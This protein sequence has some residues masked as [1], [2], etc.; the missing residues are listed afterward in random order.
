MV[1]LFAVGV[2]PPEVPRSAAVLREGT[3]T[4]TSL[5][6]VAGTPQGAPATLDQNS[7][8][9]GRAVRCYLPYNNYTAYKRY[10]AT[11]KDQHRTRRFAIDVGGEL[12]PT[13]EKDGVLVRAGGGGEGERGVI[14]NKD[15]LYKQRLAAPRQR[16][17]LLGR[18]YL[19]SERYR[20][21]N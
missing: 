10:I 15:S 13:Y 11:R 4:R 8:N 20:Y 18:D 1:P 7:I 21:I 5:V 14:D 3:E 19:Y 9:I 6:L 17:E 12:L 2:R 16:V